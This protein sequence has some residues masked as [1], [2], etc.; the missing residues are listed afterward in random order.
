[1]ELEYIYL[2]MNGCLL[3]RGSESIEI[4][5]YDLIQYLDLPVYTSENYKVSDMFETLETFGH[6]NVDLLF[7]NSLHGINFI[8]VYKAFFD[9]FT[10]DSRYSVDVSWYTGIEFD[11]TLRKDTIY[12]Y[13]RAVLMNKKDDLDFLSIGTKK[14]YELQNYN[15]IINNRYILDNPKVENIFSGLKQITLRQMIDSI[16]QEIC[17]NLTNMN[18]LKKT[19]LNKPTYRETQRKKYDKKSLKLKIIELQEK[20]NEAELV[21]DFEA[22]EEYLNEIKAINKQ[23]ENGNK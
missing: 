4:T 21:E 18:R 19:V 11:K 1:M 12:E 17:L 22:C 16:L 10:N 8:E 13:V 2:D 23:I 15:I 9:T 14:P 20:I 7:L 3:K 5:L 6:L